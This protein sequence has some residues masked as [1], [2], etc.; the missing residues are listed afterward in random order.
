MCILLWRLQDKPCCVAALETTTMRTPPDL[1]GEAVLA[2]DEPL[3][4]EVSQ[5]TTFFG[6]AQTCLSSE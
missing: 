3:L 5:A 2:N 4:C 6:L 1:L